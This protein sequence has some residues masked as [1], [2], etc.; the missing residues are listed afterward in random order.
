MTQ[1]VSRD[2]SAGKVTGCGMQTRDLIP[3][4]TSRPERFWGPHDVLSNGTENLSL[5]IM[6]IKWKTL[7]RPKER[8]KVN[9]TDKMNEYFRI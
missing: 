1:A 3:S 7:G 8:C 4:N 5:W 2:I 9:K 6:M